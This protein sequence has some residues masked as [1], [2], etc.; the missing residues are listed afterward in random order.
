MLDFSL[1]K[2]IPAD[3]TYYKFLFQLKKA[4]MG[5]YVEK[6]WGWDEQHQR[7]VF[8]KDWRAE[9]RWSIIT[10]DKIPVG[11]ILVWEIDNHIHFRHFYLLLEYQNKGI[12]S[13]VLGNELKKADEAGRVTKLGVLKIN[14]AIKLYQRL[15]FKVIDTNEFQYLMERQPESKTQ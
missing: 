10:Y 12:G 1:I 4:A 9:P 6:I 11:C 15:G 5:P 3:D 7:V 8:A 14:P 2:L 13:H